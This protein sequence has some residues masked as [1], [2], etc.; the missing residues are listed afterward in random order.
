MSGRPAVSGQVLP[1]IDD[2][3]AQV[4]ALVLAT[5]DKATLTGELLRIVL[6]AT[7]GAGAQVWLNEPEHVPQLA[8]EAFLSEPGTLA[9]GRH[10]DA[11]LAVVEQA[12]R[13]GS[14][15]IVLPASS[16]TF[17]DPSASNGQAGE[18]N[19]S[20]FY[21]V[22]APLARAGEAYGALVLWLEAEFPPRAIERVAELLESFALL[23]VPWFEQQR[24]KQLRQDAIYWTSAC[25][26]FERLHAETTLEDVAFS[27]ANGMRS[28]LGCD[29]IW[30]LL[31]KGRSSRVLA[32]SGVHQPDHRSNQLRSLRRLA[33]ALTAASLPLNWTRGSATSELAPSVRKLTNAYLDEAHLAEL[34]AVPLMRPPTANHRAVCLGMLFVE[35]FTLPA[36][37]APRRDVTPLASQLA[38]ALQNAQ[39]WRLA[40]V[41]AA[42]RNWRR[43][44]TNWWWWRPL[45]ILGT[46]AA[47]LA[48]LLW[49]PADFTVEAHGELQPAVRRHV[50]ASDDGTIQRLLVKTG[51]EVVRNQLLVELRNLELEQEM[52][53]LTGEWDTAQRRITSIEATRLDFESAPD[54]STSQRLQMTAELEELRV[55][56]ASLA[57]QRQLL[58]RRQKQL[59]LHSELGGRVLT[60]DIEAMLNGRPVRRGQQILTVADLQGPWILELQI[61]DARS[62][63]VLVARSGQ[64]EPL[65]VDFT[66]ATDPGN[67]HGG[68]LT[69]VALSTESKGGETG[70]AVLG[71]VKFDREEI[72]DLRVGARVTAKIHCGRRPLG[73]VWLIDAWRAIQRWVLF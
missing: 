24:L 40:P 50:F 7:G 54:R 11:V 60:W 2:F 30:V 20:L 19:R 31:R 35:W 27:A 12:T 21:W 70:A 37:H 17:A 63:D 56:Q 36:E 42:L 45:S 68:Q 32:A 6:A 61:P 53:R 64:A 57:K 33:G 55:T 43:T 38:V 66:L 15:K 72:R 73:Y 3:L 16:N 8:R 44:A 59:A 41:A 10:R 49:I 23:S 65:D 62:N 25:S 48:A 28:L 18:I 67:R 4:D 1:D 5:H 71:E 51:D 46:V 39:D 58:E 22:I 34:V 9:A 14:P 69:K 26:F 13:A 29:R 52:Q 47:I